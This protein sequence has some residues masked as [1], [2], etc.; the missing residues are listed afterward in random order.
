MPS[1]WMR[2]T[3]LSTRG[4]RCS[5]MNKDDW[6]ALQD[7]LDA[8][9]GEHL[10]AQNKLIAHQNVILQEIASMLAKRHVTEKTEV[11]KIEWRD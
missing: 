5:N 8:T 6:A 9:I 2:N 11:E 7:V 4:S 10:L 1:T 3:K